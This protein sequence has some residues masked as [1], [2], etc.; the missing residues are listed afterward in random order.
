M[1]NLTEMRTRLAVDHDCR[2]IT[3]DEFLGLMVSHGPIV[4]R[5]EPSLNLLGLLDEST[6]SRFLVREEDLAQISNL[7]PT[8]N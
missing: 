5:D 6:G 3:A 7:R 4:R 1:A 2:F 8:M